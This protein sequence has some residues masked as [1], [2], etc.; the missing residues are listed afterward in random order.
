MAILIDKTRRVLVQG[1]TAREGQARY[2]I[3]PSA[4]L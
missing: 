4:N 1:I 2:E 3:D